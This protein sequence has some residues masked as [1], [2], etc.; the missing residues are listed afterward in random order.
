MAIPILRNLILIL[1]ALH[2]SVAA[3]EIY[4]WKDADGKTHFSDT[5]PAG[6]EPSLK[7][8]TLPPSG[9][10]TPGQQPPAREKPASA[11]RSKAIPDSKSTAAADHL[12]ACEKART[13]LQAL[14]DKPRR[15]AVGKG[16]KFH[17]LDGEERAE[18]EAGLQKLIQEN[19]N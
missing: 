6:K 1:L 13:D 2:A 10:S 9:T 14:D 7:T 15:T 16:G 5:P 3:A 12:A 11:V 19:C 4:S 18:E 17:A 8:I